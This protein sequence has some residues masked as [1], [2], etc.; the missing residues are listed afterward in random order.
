MDRT[1]AEAATKVAIEEEAPKKDGKKVS[2][3]PEDE[4]GK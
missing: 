1:E 2:D 4:E 3:Y